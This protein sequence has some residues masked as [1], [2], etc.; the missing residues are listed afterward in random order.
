VAGPVGILDA[1]GAAALA[2]AVEV[3]PGAIDAALRGFQVGRH[4]AEEVGVINGVHYIDD[5]KATNPHAAQAS[6]LAF[7]RVVW[8]AG[9]LLK[10]ASVDDAVAGV[11]DRL[12]GVVLIGR[13]RAA[14]AEAL[15]RHA[16]DVPVIEVVA[17]EDAVMHGTNESDV[18]HGTRTVAEAGSD[19][20]LRVMAQAV[21]ASKAFSIAGGGDGSAAISAG[22][23]GAARDSARAGPQRSA[24]L[25][26]FPS[27]G[28]LAVL[29]IGRNGLGEQLRIRRTGG[30]SLRHRPIISGIRLRT[31]NAAA[32]PGIAL[33]RN[34]RHPRPILPASS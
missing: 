2:R 9:G 1:L 20:G 15:S 31:S 8:V 22:V 17:R 30:I 12:A 26:P 5:S 24:T 25:P 6:I 29:G 10:G 14:F 11:A 32:S 7:S 28:N 4:R 3:T 18:T 33:D 21:A 19:L 34:G 27:T 13:D 23:R 16:P